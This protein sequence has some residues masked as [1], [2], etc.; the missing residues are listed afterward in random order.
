M[1]GYIGAQPI[2]QTSQKRDSFTATASQTTFN[3]TGS[4]TPGYIDVYLNGVH[5]NESDY[6]ATSGTAVILNTGAALNDIIDLVYYYAL[7]MIDDGNV[8][9]TGGTIDGTAIGG[10]TPAAVTCTTFTSNGIDDNADA[11]AITIDSS[12]NVGIGR[13]PSTYRLDIEGES[14]AESRIRFR[15]PGTASGDTANVYL[16]IAGTTAESNIFFG[17]SGSSTVG[18]LRYNHSSDFMAFSTNGSEAM[19]ITSA[20]NV[21]IQ[22]TPS[23]D[24]DVHG[25]TSGAG[26][27]TELRVYNGIDNSNSN[28]NLR[29]QVTNNSASNYILFGDSSDTDVGFISYRHASN[30]MVFYTNASEAMRIYSS[31]TTKF[32]RSDDIGDVGASNTISVADDATVD[33]TLAVAE[34]A[35]CGALL[36]HAYQTTSGKG[37]LFFADYA[38]TIT[39]IAGDASWVNSDTDTNYCI[40]K[41][42]SSHDVTFKNRNGSTQTFAI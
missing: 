9:I 11:V 15:N 4:Y 37:A 22:C 3:T 41:S 35:D 2:P 36:I 18:I 12:E 17:D 40:Y 19:R 8:T 33:L 1:S 13:S 42:A 30:N 34:A 38:G 24:L 28:A 21:G 31:G 25:A 14:G 10:T 26:D 7:D 27:D 16:Q 23:Y 6:T 29:L 32:S 5:L 39:K 20:G